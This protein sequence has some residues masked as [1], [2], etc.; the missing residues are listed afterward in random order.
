MTPTGSSSP[1]GH[2]HTQKARIPVR[3]LRGRRGGWPGSQFP[4]LPSCLLSSPSLGSISAGYWVN[5][6]HHQSFHLP[7]F[8]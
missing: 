4:L 5:H 8:I 6:S 3:V 2:A 1:K 7:S